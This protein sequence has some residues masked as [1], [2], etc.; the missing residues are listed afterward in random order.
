MSDTFNCY[1]EFH[2]TCEAIIRQLPKITNT[3]KD[4]E[5]C[6]VCAVFPCG[7]CHKVRTLFKRNFLECL[8]LDVSSFLFKGGYLRS[9]LMLAFGRKYP[10][11]SVIYNVFDRIRYLWQL[12]LFLEAK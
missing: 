7:C 5:N 1:S 11:Y 10:T 8:Q 9:N 2:A 6:G 3:I 12:P 4:I